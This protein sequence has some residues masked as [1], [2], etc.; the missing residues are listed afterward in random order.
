MA[1]VKQRLA[2]RAEEESTS[3]ALDGDEEGDE[4]VYADSDI[5][6]EAAK[7]R[8]LLGLVPDGTDRKYDTLVRAL[9]QLRRQ[10]PSERF[11]IFTQYRETLEF[12]REELGKIY[13]GARIAT[14]KGGP[15]DDKIAAIEAFWDEAGARFLI[16]TSAGGEGINLQIGRILFNYDLP[17]NPM[18]VEQRIGRIHRYGQQ[19]TVQVYNLVAEDTVEE[20]IYRLLEEKLL[21]IAGAIGKLDPVTGEV[22]EDFRSE[23]L[24]FLGTAPNYQDLYKKALVDPDYKRT[25][26][27]M[28]DAIERAREASEALRALTQDLDAFNLEHYRTLRGHFTLEHLGLFVE[29][30]I[31]RL[32][33]A[34]VPSGPLVQIETPEPLM[35]YPGVVRSYR[36]VAFD[37]DLAMRRKNVQLLGLGHP[38]VDA[39]IRHFQRPQQP[40]DVAVL[41]GSSGARG[42][43]SA[44]AIVYLDLDNGRRHSQYVNLLVDA[45]GSWVDAPPAVDA[46]VLRSLDREPVV[47]SVSHDVPAL[48]Q[49]TESAVAAVTAR[50]RA[51]VEGLASLRSALVALASY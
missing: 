33:G 21:E 18:A 23:I 15:L 14:I 10:N 7:V 32:G 22:V 8:D 35:G 24:G 6:D 43:L 27:E 2:R 11:V 17:W 26:R 40:G 38:L 48:R 31:L 44:R 50:L 51:D 12:L 28:A 39:L 36:D 29:R 1:Q 5:P 25:E 30:A 16:C 20:R 46:E 37:R 41:V 13:G 45:N 47:E 3:W 9:E 49:G 4:G 34:F 42:Q 19:D